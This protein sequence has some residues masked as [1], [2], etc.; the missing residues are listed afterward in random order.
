MIETTP[1]ESNEELPVPETYGDVERLAD[2]MEQLPTPEMVEALMGLLKPDELREVAEG[3]L[4]DCTEA[5]RKQDILE[6]AEA[7][8]SWIATAEE[9]ITTRKRFSSLKKTME[10]IRAKYQKTE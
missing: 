7:I 1:P 6:N 10:E 2:A 3:I 8:N 9:I 5:T 4:L